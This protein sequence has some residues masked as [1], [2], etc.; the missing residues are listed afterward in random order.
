MLPLIGAF[1]IWVPVSIYL[2]AMGRP[3]EAAALVGYGTLVSASDNYLR[4]ALIGRTSAFNSAIVVVGIFGGLVVFGAVGLFIG[5]VIL[6]G[7][8][9]TSTYSLESETTAGT[10]N[11]RRIPRSTPRRI[12]ALQRTTNRIRI[13]SRRQDRL[14][15]PRRRSRK[16]T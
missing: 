15:R 14:T 5:P 13:S 3:L 12:P 7:A 4:P 1:G 11:R 9:V 2:F 10:T 8:K 16:P 6:G